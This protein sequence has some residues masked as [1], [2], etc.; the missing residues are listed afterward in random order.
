MT[1]TVQDHY[2][3]RAKKEDYLARSVYKL[4]Q[5]QKKYKILRA[6]ARVLDL[7]AAPGSWLQLAG[8]IAGHSG[9]VAGIDIK[10]FEHSFPRHVLT[11]EGD[12]FDE[13]FTGK[14]LDAYGPFDVVLS[15]MAPSTSGI[16]VADCARSALLFER[17]L[18][19]ARSALKP[20]GHFLGKIFQGSEFHAILIEIKKQFA[21]V[22]VIRPDATRK[23]SKEVYILAMH[24]KRK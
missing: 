1:Y 23:Q 22:R 3:R 18:E 5:I 16:R 2:F 4:E 21:Q 13:E 9:F 10:P 12:I 11:F 6:G 19:I 8:S 15:D 17:A 20:E 24:L 7:G 14:I